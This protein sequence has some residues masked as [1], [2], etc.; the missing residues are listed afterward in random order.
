MTQTSAL[1]AGSYPAHA[2]FKEVAFFK[3]NSI[4]IP[5]HSKPLETPRDSAEAPAV[6]STQS[7]P[8]RRRK[9]AET[10]KRSLFQRPRD[11]LV[12]EDLKHLIRAAPIHL[13]AIHLLKRFWRGAKMEGLVVIRGSWLETTT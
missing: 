2:R 13:R 11:E 10:L 4:L 7:A 5:Q 12:N 6:A 3:L 8:K 9:E 1:G